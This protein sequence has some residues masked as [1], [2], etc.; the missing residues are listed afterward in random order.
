MYHRDGVRGVFLCGIGE[1]LDFYLTMKL[2]DDPSLDPDAL[3]NEFFSR[4]FG[5]AAEPMRAF[6]TRI[7]EIFNNPANYPDEVRQVEKQ[8]HQTETLAW[9]YLGTAERMK[10]L[11]TF[12]ERAG[13]LAVRDLEKKRVRTWQEGVWDY[14]VKGRKMYLAKP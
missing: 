14:M 13:Q 7:E 3:L 8:F 2:Y 4:Y 9:K 5:A 1:Q 6:Y 12:I 10:E 11:G